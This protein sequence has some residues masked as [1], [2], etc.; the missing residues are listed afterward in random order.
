[1][2]EMSEMS[3]TTRRI[4]LAGAVGASAAAAVAACGGGGGSGYGSGGAKQTS[5]AQPPQYGGQTST[6]PA[7]SSAPGGGGVLA[8][9]SEIPVGGGKI[10][11]VQKVVVTQPTAGQFNAFSAICTHMGCTVGTVSGGIITCP[12]HG[13]QYSIQDGSVVRGP[14][15]K[16]LAAKQ[17]TVSGDEITVTG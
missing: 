7:T 1:M 5:A 16:A 11:D 8:K 10:F 9:T 14:A 6:A 2:S 3:E 13:S 17:V 4:V 12:C 15:P